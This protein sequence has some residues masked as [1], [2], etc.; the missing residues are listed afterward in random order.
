MLHGIFVTGT[1]TNV[2]KTVVS[3]ALMHRY[4]DEATLKYWKPI[5]TGIEQDDDTETVRALAGCS[6]EAMFVPGVRLHRP[7]APYLAAELSGVRIRVAD[8]EQCVADEPED[9][10][11]VVE[12]IGGVLVPLNDTEFVT[13]LIARLALPVLVVA[14]SELGTINQ[15]LLT[16]EALRARMIN[17]L[18]VI[19][20]GARN[21][22]NRNAIERWG[23]VEVFGEMP[24]FPRL[25]AD[26]LGRWAALE[27]DPKGKLTACFK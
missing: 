23:Q 13:D 4:R 1:D 22:E 21:P 11:W 12:G 7:L 10:G 14:S 20:V 5:Q 18:G 26:E 17:I 27:F 2:G 19:M 8:L 15:S 25:T 9:I 24:R 16:L 6:A 3:A